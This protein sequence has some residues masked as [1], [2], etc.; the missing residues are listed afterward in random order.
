MSN[1]TSTKLN[2]APVLALAQDKR[3][4][5]VDGWVGPKT[6]PK[7]SMESPV[8]S[9]ILRQPRFSSV[10][11]LLAQFC[12]NH[13]RHP[14]PRLSDYKLPNVNVKWFLPEPPS[15]LSEISVG[16]MFLPTLK[17][18][19]DLAA[20]SCRVRDEGMISHCVEPGGCFRCFRPK[21]QLLPTPVI[22]SPPDNKLSATPEH[23]RKM[24]R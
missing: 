12:W 9:S 17:T 10:I 5:W 16:V 14:T 15:H 20:G 13:Q 18:L 11:R 23:G 19:Q 8:I 24:S 3:A 2:E 4:W 22:V 1:S 7:A 21:R 6:E